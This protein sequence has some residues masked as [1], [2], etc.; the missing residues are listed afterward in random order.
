MKA[1]ILIRCSVGA[2]FLSEGL[3][4]F[5]FPDTV[6]AL[7]FKS[8]GIPFPEFT[9]PFVGSFEIACGLLVLMGLMIRFAVIP[10]LVIITTAIITTKIPI[11]F[12]AGFFKMAHEARTDYSM[13][14]SLLFLLL[15]G[16]GYYSLDR[17]LSVKKGKDHW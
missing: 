11:L 5:L 7:R 16:A 1:I 8:I 12:S 4:K 14:L 17:A 9:A 15:V 13:L 10:L 3:Q 2:I 6:G